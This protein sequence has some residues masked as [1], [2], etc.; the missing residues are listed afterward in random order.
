MECLAHTSNPEAS[1]K[2]SD[3]VMTVS[4][5]PY[6]TKLPVYPHA[7]IEVQINLED[8]AKQSIDTSKQSVE[9]YLYL[10]GYNPLKFYHVIKDIEFD[11]TDPIQ[12]EVFQKV[13]KVISKSDTIHKFNLEF[14]NHKFEILNAFAWLRAG[15]RYNYKAD[16]Y[17]QAIY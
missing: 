12:W 3:P 6:P 4:V 15:N 16:H 13:S 2:V 8:L 14:M 7:G 1:F 17:H 10:K 11:C 9:Y 5:I